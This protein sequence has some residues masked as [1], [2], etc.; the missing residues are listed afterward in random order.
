MELQLRTMSRRMTIGT[1][2][3]SATKD[4]LG[5]RA[6]LIEIK[7]LDAPIVATNFPLSVKMICLHFIRSCVLNGIPQRTKSSP[8][9]ICRR[10]MRMLG[11]YVQ[12]VM[13]IKLK[14]M[15]ALMAAAVPNASRESLIKDIGYKNSPSVVKLKKSYAGASSV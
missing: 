14:S 13:S 9:I 12:M 6:L 2:I 5:W 11:G 3:G 4:T 15:H 1:I 8:L 10:V 7:E